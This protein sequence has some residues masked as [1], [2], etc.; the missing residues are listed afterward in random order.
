MHAL[1]QLGHITGETR[2]NSLEFH[3]KRRDILK[4]PSEYSSLTF[5]RSFFTFK[6]KK[7]I[8]IIIIVTTIIITIIKIKII[9][10]IIITIIIIIIIIVNARNLVNEF[11]GGNEMILSQKDSKDKQ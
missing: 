6:L 9:I 1:K 7:N 10:I 4:W 2:S 3:C 5:S 8:I 11:L